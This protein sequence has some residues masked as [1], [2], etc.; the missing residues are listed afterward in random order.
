[1]RRTPLL[2]PL[3][4]WASVAFGQAPASAELWRVYATSLAIPAALQAGPL[5]PA[6][7]PAAGP[8]DGA[9]L[10][11]LHIVHT[12][13]IL[14]LSGFTGGVTKSVSDRVGLGMQ[15]GRIDIRD[16]VRTTT[17]PSSVGGPIPVYTQY[18]GLG[19]RL[20]VHTLELGALVRVNNERF[21]TIDETG[22]TLDLGLRFEPHRHIA[23]AAASHFLPIDLS[24]QP[25]TDYY[26]GIEYEFL[27][28]AQI[29][30]ISSS[31]LARLG[32]TY[33]A[34]G[35]LEPSIGTGI[36]LGEY[37]GLNASVTREQAHGLHAWR[38]A[39]S[40]FLRVG[41]YQVG[42]ARASSLNDVG[43]TYRVGLDVAISQ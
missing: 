39:I 36:F 42:F 34:Y 6:W 10:G 38:P 24:K 3:I 4:L 16:L 41:R 37:F 29:G 15:L 31:V 14:G 12:S 7:N 35:A 27:S 43:A 28:A 1:V 32:T 13:S 19:G 21:D 33:R 25:T 5:G 18:L 30:S 22:L 26:A 23:I 2:I 11:G 9:L 8:R 17:S 40:L 20:E